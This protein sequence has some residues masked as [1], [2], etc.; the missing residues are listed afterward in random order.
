ML[1]LAAIVRVASCVGFVT[2]TAVSYFGPIMRF[3]SY[4]G[5]VIE[6]V[7]S[8][9]G[10]GLDFAIICVLQVSLLVWLL[11]YRVCELILVTPIASYIIDY[12]SLTDN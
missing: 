2:V 7:V 11:G 1:V 8:C 3:S 4:V 12:G 6:R 5:S 10:S 9:F